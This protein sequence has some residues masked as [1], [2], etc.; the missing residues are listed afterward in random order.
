MQ[1]SGHKK[2]RGFFQL[3]G[4][5]PAQDRK[6]FIKRFAEPQGPSVCTLPQYYEIKE[7]EYVSPIQS[8]A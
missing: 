6:R 7:P 4:A 3:D 8:T 1:E 5:T 2:N